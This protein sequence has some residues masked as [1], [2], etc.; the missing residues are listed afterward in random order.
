VIKPTNNA[1]IDTKEVA[2]FRRCKGESAEGFQ[3][4]LGICEPLLKGRTLRM[5]AWDDS[6]EEESI[7]EAELNL[8]SEV[9]AGLLKNAIQNWNPY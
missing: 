6:G 5:T 3:V 1:T 4:T 7:L 8:G 2:I 9:G